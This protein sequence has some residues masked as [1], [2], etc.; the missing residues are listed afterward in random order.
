MQSSPCELVYP[1]THGSHAWFSLIMCQYCCY[2]IHHIHGV[3]ARG[4]SRPQSKSKCRF[5]G[6]KS[7]ISGHWYLISR[8]KLI[9]WLLAS[10]ENFH[11]KYLPAFPVKF[12]PKHMIIQWS[13]HAHDKNNSIKFPDLETCLFACILPFHLQTPF[14]NFNYCLASWIQQWMTSF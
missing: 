1:G 3:W 8:A 2:Y 7:L 13:L 9:P 11:G 4:G 5:Q 12:L 14:I 10:R 6:K